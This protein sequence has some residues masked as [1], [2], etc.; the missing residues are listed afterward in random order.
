MCK[1]IYIPSQFLGTYHRPIPSILPTSLVVPF[2]PIFIHMPPYP[3]IY[4][5]LGT[6]LRTAGAI[7]WKDSSTTY[8]PST[9]MR[10]KSKY[11]YEIYIQPKYRYE[12]TTTR[13]PLAPMGAYGHPWR[14]TESPI[15]LMSPARDMWNDGIQ[16]CISKCGVYYTRAFTI[17]LHATVKFTSNF[18][19]ENGHINRR[20]NINYLFDLHRPS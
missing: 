13:V 15:S 3:A 16:I 6:F 4:S 11:S 2:I 17:S 1:S 19:W 5:L 9:G 7:R 10:V 14:P 20:L 8:N 18:D 12:G